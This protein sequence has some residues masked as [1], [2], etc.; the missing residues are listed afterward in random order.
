[1]REFYGLNPKLLMRYQ[2]YLTEWIK[3]N[4]DERSET[5]WIN[6]IYIQRAIGASFSKHG[7]YPED[8][9][10]LYSP[11]ETATDEDGE[12]YVVTDADRFFAFATMFNKAHEKEFADKKAEVIDAEVVDGI[13][14]EAV[15]DIST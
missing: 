2:P 1:M 8:Y 11:E 13:A 6:G 14:T 12:T 9:I 15:D 5:G 7:K 10:R 3:S 4:S